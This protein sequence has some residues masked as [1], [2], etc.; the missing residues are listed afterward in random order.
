MTLHILF[1][2][3]TFMQNVIDLMA[4]GW[5]NY[6]TCRQITGLEREVQDT[7]LTIKFQLFCRR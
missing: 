1:R 3:S 6:S 2:V 5:L 7:L 4:T